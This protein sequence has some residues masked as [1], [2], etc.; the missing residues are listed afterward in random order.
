VEKFRIDIILE[1]G[2]KR[3]V[4]METALLLKYIEELGSLSA[5]AKKLGIPYS[6]AWQDI[7]RAEAALGLRLV[8]ARRGAAGGA[9]LTEAG[10]AILRR[11]VEVAERKAGGLEAEVCDFVYAGSS[12]EYI[13]RLLSRLREEGYCVEVH[14]VGSMAGLTMAA[15]GLADVAGA[16]LLDPATGE[17]NLPYIERL[18]LSTIALFRGYMRSIGFAY[19]PDVE[20]RGVEDLFKYR[21][22]NRNPGSGTRTLLEHLLSLYAQRSGAAKASLAAKIKGYEVEVRTHEEVAKALVEGKADVGLAIAAV[23]EGAGL[24][25]RQVALE[26]FDI[27]VNKRSLQKPAAALLLKLLKEEEPPP[28]YVPLKN[29]GEAIIR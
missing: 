7:A 2:D 4:D 11:Y 8:E 29:S 23:A 14:W 10:A 19:R 9:R 17:Y 15:L 20:F 5:A 1:K 16:H 26:R 27:A 13:L 3:A 28:G 25:F 21:F 12:D 18:G 22:I 24:G 6:R